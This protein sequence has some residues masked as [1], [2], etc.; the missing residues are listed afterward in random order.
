MIADGAR[1]PGR[2]S[3]IIRAVENVSETYRLKIESGYVFISFPFPDGG[4]KC[5]GN[6]KCKG[7]EE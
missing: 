4:C 3:D 1:R 5:G 7:G 6:C 2:V